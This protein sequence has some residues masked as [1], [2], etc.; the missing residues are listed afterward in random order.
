MKLSRRTALA[1]GLAAFLPIPCL[2]AAQD[3]T[4]RIDA[5]LSH[6]PWIA[7]GRPSQRYVYVLFA[8]WCPYCKVLFVE[9]RRGHDSI[10]F[11]W[12]AGGSR[13]AM[14]MNQNLNA[15]SRRSTDVLA[16][17]FRHATLDN[18]LSDDTAKALLARSESTI[19]EISARLSVTGYP[20][21][22]FAD[23]RG[24]VRTLGG[25]PDDLDEF[26][27]RVGVFPSAGS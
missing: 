25:V 16:G 26:F 24:E 17:I 1:S 12:I 9:T 23:R 20:T 27:A 2:A 8:P 21:L 13:D 19:E 18:L 10:Q 7:D 5:I 22:I 11:R 15:V 14:S 3:A 6:A 4:A